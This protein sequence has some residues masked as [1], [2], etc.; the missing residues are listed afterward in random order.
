MTIIYNSLSARL[1]FLSS[2]AI[3][4]SKL[5]SK[6]TSLFAL[7]VMLVFVHGVKAQTTLIDATTNNGGFESGSTGWTI[8]GAQTNQWRVS[9]GAT[10]GFSGTQCAYISNSTVAPFAHTYSTG[11]TSGGSLYRDFTFPAGETSISLTFKWISRGEANWDRMRVW[12]VPTSVTPSTAALLASGAAPTGNVQLGTNYN[13]QATWTTATITI[14]AAYAGTTSRLVFQWRNDNSGGTQ[15]PAAFDDVTIITTCTGAT[16]AAASNLTLTSATANWNAFVG[17]TG[18]NLRYRVVGSPTWTNLTGLSGTSTS[19]TSLTSSTSYEYQIQATGPVCNAWSSSAT[20]FTGYCLA[21]STSQASWISA[22]SAS[23]SASS[24]S[25]TNISHTAASGAAGGYLNLTST[26]IT[27]G[28]IGGTTNLS[29]TC[30]GPTCGFAVWVDW[31]NDLTFAAGERMFVTAT[32]VTTTTGS[33]AVPAG[34]PN[35]SYRMRVITDWNIGAPASACGNIARGEFK[36]FTFQVVSPPPAPTITSFTPSSICP[37]GTLTITGTDLLGATVANVKIGGTAVS[38]ITSND[39]TTLVCVV[40]SGTTGTVAVTTAG[41]TGTSSGTLTFN[42]FP[43]TPV[44]TAATG[45][46]SAGFTANWG[47]AASATSYILDVSTSISFASFVS[48]YNGL[49]VGNVLTY[50]ITGLSPL[51]TYYIRVR[52]DNGLCP[53]VNSTSQTV[54]TLAAAPF[55]QSFTGITSLPAGWSATPFFWYIGTATGVAGNPA[56]AIYTNLYYPATASFTLPTIEPLPAN[57]IFTYDYQISDY[58]VTTP[59][60]AGWGNFQWQI[61]ANGGGFVNLGAAVT[62]PS[63]ASYIAGPT[64]DLSS[65]VGQTV[66][67]RLNATYATGDYNLSF[68]NIKVYVPCSG[69]PSAGAAGTVLPLA[70][71]A[72]N[73]SAV[74]AS[75]GAGYTSGAD[76]TYQWQSSADG[77]TFANISGATSASYASS[78]TLVLAPTYYRNIITCT[79]SGLSTTSTP[80]FI[81]AAF[82]QPS[83]SANPPLFCG[84]GGTSALTATISGGN[85]YDTYTWA[86]GSGQTGVLSNET[87]TTAEWTITQSAGFVYTV[88]DTETGCT[89]EV[90][91][92]VNVLEGVSP[93][94]TATPSIVCA[95]GTSV[96]ASG[97]SAGNFSSTAIAHN[98]ISAGTGITNALV[99]AGTQVVPL[100][101][102]SLDDGGWAGVPIGFTFNFFGTNYT[103]VNVSTNGLVTFGTYNAAAM[104][105]YDFVTLPSTTEPNP[106]VA[107][108]AMDNNLGG[109]LGGAIRTRTLGFPGNRIFI[110][111]YEAVQEYADTKFSTAQM[112]LYE[113]TGNIEVHVTS[114]TNIDQ[115]KLVGVNGPGGAIGALAY[116]SGDV[117]SATNPISTPFAY[118]F[119]PP[120]DYTCTWTPSVNISGAA[121]ATNLFSRTTN[122][123]NTAG[124]INFNLNLINQQSGCISNVA[125]PV[126]VVDDPIAPVSASIEAYG[127]SLGSSSV[128][129]TPLTVCG[130]Q[131]VKL[132]YVGSLGATEQV[133]WYNAATGGTLLATNDTLDIAGLSANDT[134]WV[135]INNGACAE[136]GRFEYRIN[137][138]T[139]PTVTVNSLGPDDDVNCGE[140]PTYGMSYSLTSAASPAYTYTWSTDGNATTFADNG[141]G[142]ATLTSDVTTT[143]TWTAFQAG[144]GCTITAGKSFGIYPFPVIVPTAA[145]TAICIGDTTQIFSNLST[146]NFSV[147]CVPFGYRTAPPSATFLANNGVRNTSFGGTASLDDG[148][149]ADVPLGFTFSYFGSDFTAVNVGT[150]GVINFGPYANFN[151]GQFNFP[152][153]F[154]S[155]TNPVNTIGVL[156]HDLYLSASGT[157]R[158]WTEGAAPN[159]VFVIEYNAPGFITDGLAQAQAHLY[160]TLGIVEIHVQQ[161]TSVLKAKTIGLQNGAGTVGATAPVQCDVNGNQVGIA[162]WSAKTSTIESTESQAWR[163]SPP[164]SYSFAWSPSAEIAGSATGS[165]ALAAPTATVGG[166]QSYFVTVSDNLSGCVG[167]PV[168]LEFDLIAPVAAPNVVGYGLLSDLDGTNT[169]TFCA[170]QDIE[171][172]VEAGVGYDSTYNAV[173]YSQEVGGTGFYAAYYDTVAY[174]IAGPAG[175]SSDDSLWISIDNGIC[176]GPRR[177]VILDFQEPDSLVV[178]NSSPVNCGPSSTTYTSNLSVSS[179]GTYTYTWAPAGALDVTTGTDVVATVNQ[180]TNVTLTA[181]DA[182]GFCTVTETSPVSVFGFPTV[183]PTALN[184]SICPG[185]QTLLYSNT[186]STGFTI[187]STGYSPTPESGSTTLVLNGVVNQAL[188][189]GGLDDGVWAGIPIGFT[190]NFLGNDY[191]T[192][193]VS[194]NGNIQFGPTY[195]TDYIPTFGAAAPN[196]FIA[197]FWTDMNFGSTNG[198]NTIRYWTSGTS[199]NRVFSV[200]FAGYRFGGFASDQRLAGQ[201]DLF[202]S[203]GLA[204]ANIQEVVANGF[205]NTIVGCENAT[206][207]IGSAAPG[208]TNATWFTTAQEAWRFIP[209]VDYSFSWLPTAEIDVTS[210]AG[211]TTAVAT[212]NSTTINLTAANSNVAV[213]MVVTGSGIPANT[214]V[215][216]ITSTTQFVLSGPASVPASSALTFAWT[217]TGPI[218]LVSPSANTQYQLIVTDNNTGCDNSIN[219]QTFVD[220]AIASAPP[221]ASFV[222]NDLTATTGGVLQTVNFTNNTVLLGGETFVWTFSPNTV[223]FAGSTNATSANPQVQFMEPGNYS[224]TLTV[225]SCTGID[226]LVRTNYISVTPEYCFPVFAPVGCDEGDGV[227]GVRITNPASVIVMQ[228]LTTGCN[229]EPGAYIEYAPVAG[230]TTATLYQGTTYSMQVTSISPTFQEF[231][232]AYLDVDDDGDFND[233]LEFLGGNFS[234]AQSA[235]FDIGIPTSNVTYG[236]HRL[237]VIAAF[238][239]GPLDANDACIETTYGE[240]HD[241]IVNIQPP[242]V[243]NDIPAFATNVQYSVNLNYPTCYPITGSTALATNSPESAGSTGNDIWFRFTAQSTGVSITLT[244]ATMDDYIGLYSRD[245]AGNYNL[246]AFENAGTGAGDFERL[247]VGGLTA[248]TQY[249]VS[250]GSASAGAGGAYSLCI[251]NLMPSSCAYAIPATGFPLCNAFKAIYRGAPSQGVTYNFTFTPVLP[252]PGAATTITGT[253]GLITLSNAALALRYGGVYNAKVDVLYNL[254]NTATTPVAEPILVQGNPAA[255]T[256]TN[257]PIQAH[258]LMEVRFSQRCPATLLRSNF[259][260]GATVPGSTSSFVCGATN[261]EYEFTQVVSCTDGTLFGVADTLTTVANTPYLGLGVLGNLPNAGAWNVRIRPKFSYGVGTF[262]PVQRILVNNTSASA[263]LDE[264]VAE[265]DEKVDSFVAANLYPNP[266]NGEMVNLNVS[267]IESDNVFVRIT[268]AMGRIVYT[269][270]FAVEGSLNTI[271]TFAEPLASGIYNVEFTVDGQIMAERMIVA[272][273]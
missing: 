136:T 30:G 78:P 234:A 19:L 137:Y 114:S 245:L 139:P 226:D 257:I 248:G 133:K 89:K 120:A 135:A 218:A 113:A 50:P 158:F 249:W 269:N 25:T 3:K 201:I 170:E 71:L 9:T 81:D 28:F 76:V 22:F 32:Y 233:P 246:V 141:G 169:I 64:I 165:T 232:A 266:N 268:D 240:A 156:A 82:G 96:L 87:N 143:S 211:T 259:L 188:T 264:E 267:G 270:R 253:N 223:Q 13:S 77:T 102:G 254:F 140:G 123:L 206:G 44:F 262:G 154:P 204:V 1:R 210:T 16:T 58:G 185:G 235:T 52:G 216:S 212:T 205:R 231:F 131:D 104:A 239:T 6:L 224:V 65:Y 90:R 34:T 108:L 27:S 61:N 56:N 116:N 263:M 142:S 95:G 83:I 184:D 182:T 145:D 198:P 72:C 222:A 111:S 12:L 199:P 122:A 88:V 24:V 271:V 7:T 51:T 163:F 237:R 17:A 100:S 177:L 84:A 107:I 94:P 29:M 202:E 209:P 193:G 261:Y 183:N 46:G 110:V 164:V 273:Q 8:G 119:Q 38:S 112:H 80:V 86:V 74:T 67:L 157:I 117:P 219:N 242:V 200:A 191:T 103:T 155:P 60:A 106:M 174:A 73:G 144:T 129:Q 244:S 186:T 238:G 162:T 167:T 149:W 166:V 214:T 247:N 208:R 225:T 14:P 75:L 41:G 250:V 59:T 220:V 258:P 85:P 176:E 36:D 127:S 175:I 54:V 260:V 39:G 172:Y 66:Q 178:T 115:V 251:Q 171:L 11:S 161:A 91:Q 125:I 97:L 153:G 147:K 192:V 79:T 181:V 48:G 187:E 4:D 37:G 207:T 31:N 15:P 53:G 221:V 105:D 47:A 121:T 190:F 229:T 70:G 98:T 130:V 255:P 168:E 228:H 57:Y 236:P 26:D 241:Y 159:R 195:S 2:V 173:Y 43:A 101:T 243:L 49:N 227:G 132:V 33:F 23:A 189:L 179:A 230:V 126:T 152:G 128:A 197:L 118:R 99:N 45:I 35:G 203:T 62:A 63:G 109:A 148:G 194:T 150:N 213:G 252:T 40:G 138:N 217:T 146:T 93:T 10:A 265:M 5:G 18:Y 55:S 68:D 272:K 160:E 42:A 134:V 256:C 20:F 69:T 151:A 196:N 215:S 124:T 21:S 180:T 92:S